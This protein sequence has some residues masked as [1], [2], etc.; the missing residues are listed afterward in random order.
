MKKALLS[1]VLILFSFGHLFSQ[2]ISELDSSQSGGDNE[3][4][5]EIGG[6]PGTSLTGYVLIA[7]NGFNDQVYR[8]HDLDGQTIDA[9]G[10][11]TIGNA[12]GVNWTISPSESWIQ[13]GADAVALVQTG[14]CPSLNTACTSIGGTIVSALV[15]DNN[16]PDDMGLLTCLGQTVQYDEGQNGNGTTE[17]LQFDGISWFAATPT[18]GAENSSGLPISLISF[19]A[20]PMEDERGIK[21]NWATSYEENNEYFSIE[22]STDGITF[23]EVGIKDGI[24]NSSVVNTYDFIHKDLTIGTHYYRLQ[25]M[26]YNGDFEYSNVVT[27]T[28]RNNGGFIS[29]FPNP[30]VDKVNI[31]VGTPFSKNAFFQLLNIQGQLVRTYNLPEDAHSFDLEMSDFP[32][33]VYYIQLRLD[34]EITTHKIIKQ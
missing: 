4:F 28:L 18:M 9:N 15:Y 34:N 3:E 12:T 16:D 29:L 23:R 19:D 13:N 2:F 21:L 20:N 30:T 27:A 5:V 31:Q 14:S 1:F 32:N 26:D 24:G 17:S 25:Q 8:C 33:G 11:F 7:V 10:F 22:H 6:T